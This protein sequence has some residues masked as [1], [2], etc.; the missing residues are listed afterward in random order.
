[1]RPLVGDERASFGVLDRDECLLLLKWE[2]IGRLAVQQEDGGAPIVVPVNFVLLDGETVCIRLDLGE[3]AQRAIARPVS[4]QVDRFDWYRRIG[5]SV[6]VQG[7]ARLLTQHEGDQL[8][9]GPEPWAPGEHPLLV[10]IEP[11]KI[12]GRRIELADS[13]LDARGYR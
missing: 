9:V 2:A 3:I 13:P 10:R 4:F 5:W 12:T 1:M 8:E 6:L 7:A 11:E